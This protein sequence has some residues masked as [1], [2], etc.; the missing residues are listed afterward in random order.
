VV[1]VGGREA[2][3]GWGV[4]GVECG[5][6]VGLPGFAARLRPAGCDLGSPRVSVARTGKW[7]L[8]NVACIPAE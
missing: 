3:L 2:G 8:K 1:S 4:G 6:G 5:S 7:G